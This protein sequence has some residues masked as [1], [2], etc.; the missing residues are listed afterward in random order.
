MIKHVLI[1]IMVIIVVI[2]C[3]KNWKYIWP[4]AAGIFGTLFILRGKPWYPVCCWRWP[5]HHGQR[6]ILIPSILISRE[7]FVEKL[8]E[9]E[10]YF[11]WSGSTFDQSLQK[12][13]FLFSDHTYPPSSVICQINSTGETPS[14][15]YFLQPMLVLETGTIFMCGEVSH[16]SW[17]IRFRQVISVCV[18]AICG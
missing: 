4:V 12:I 5:R 3:F 10:N 1:A 16:F 11:G 6:P 9:A 13:V 7:K 18:P 14:P 15:G 2:L 17:L 8:I